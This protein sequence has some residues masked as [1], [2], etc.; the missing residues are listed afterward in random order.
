MGVTRLFQR[1]PEE[2]NL[3]M[4]SRIIHWEESHLRGLQLP[5][6]GVPFTGNPFPFWQQAFA[7]GLF[8]MFVSRSDT[9]MLAVTGI[10]LRE[11]SC[12][13]GSPFKP[14]LVC[15]DL[16]CRYCQAKAAPCNGHVKVPLA[17]DIESSL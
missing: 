15:L 10:W 5:G 6:S 4:I 8:D 14:V 16:P 3:G 2:P 1:T 12:P 13:W 17:Q 11:S 7:N 9:C